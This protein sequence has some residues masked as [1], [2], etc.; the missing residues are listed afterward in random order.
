[1]MRIPIIK[2]LRRAGFIALIN[3]LFIFSLQAQNYDLKGYVLDTNHTALKNVNIR[4]ENQKSGEVS[5]SKGYFN[6]K[7]KS[8]PIT[9]I[10][11]HI[12]Y[13]TRKLTITDVQQNLEIILHKET[14][15]LSSVDIRANAIVNLVEK[16]KLY[17]I[18]YAFQNDSIVLLSYKSRHQNEAQLLVLD[19]T[20]DNLLS[21]SLNNIDQI[22]SDLLDRNHLLGDE[23]ARLIIIHDSIIEFGS[24]IE[25]EEFHSIKETIIGYNSSFYYLRQNSMGNQVVKLFRFDTRNK[26]LKLLKEIIDE[27][28]L[29][30]LGDKGRLQSA[31]NYTE[32]DA[33]FEEMCFYAPKFIPLIKI[34]SLFYLF[35]FGQDELEIIDLEGNTLSS[36]S[37]SFHHARTWEQQILVD[38]INNKAYAV[39]SKNGIYSIA[40]INLETGEIASLIKVPN[41]PHIEKMKVHNGKLYFLFKGNIENRYKELYSMNL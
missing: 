34:Q 26:E 1:M 8:L 38:D 19:E 28:G 21:K 10:V 30:R 33:R 24:E 27:P 22:Q 11:S 29:E 32:S 17:V 3:L 36:T 14:I 6:L 20:G 5:N 16:K 2:H 7:Q 39:F 35:N 41:L 18:D 23:S 9:L 4:I 25:L 40:N 13:K 12:G 15:E 31:A 37:L